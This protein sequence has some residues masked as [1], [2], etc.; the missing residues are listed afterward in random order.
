MKYLVFFTLLFATLNSF[1]NTFLVKKFQKKI[2]SCANKIV[3][4]N[5]GGHDAP[6]YAQTFMLVAMFDGSLLNDPE[7]VDI[8]AYVADQCEL[9]RNNLPS[10]KRSELDKSKLEASIDSLSD[11]LHGAAKTKRIVKSMYRKDKGFNCDDGS[12]KNSLFNTA[13]KDY[14]NCL[15]KDR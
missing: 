2:I 8:L 10:F 15:L 1:A 7:K 13:K 3:L 4:E 6:D 5:R 12:S 11:E 14:L 9:S